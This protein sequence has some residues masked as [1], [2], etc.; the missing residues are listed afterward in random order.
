MTWVVV[1]LLP[2]ADDEG[3]AP[4]LLATIPVVLSTAP[5]VLPM[6]PVVLPVL[7]I[8]V[9]SAG[10][11]VVVLTVAW[12]AVTLPGSVEPAPLP[13]SLVLVATVVVMMVVGL[14][15]LSP[16]VVLVAT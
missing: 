3:S 5:V 2:A 16:V 12:D 4:V 13:L 14:A 8:D 10:V 9:T 15:V 7:A 11:V 1:E 6:A